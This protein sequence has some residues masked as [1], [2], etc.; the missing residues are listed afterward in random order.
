MDIPQ[1]ADEAIGGSLCIQGADVPNVKEAGHLIRHAG[2]T[3]WTPTG[4]E[5]EG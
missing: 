1:C 4:G 3:Q 5:T 2:H